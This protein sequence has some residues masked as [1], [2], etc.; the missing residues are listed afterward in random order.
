MP[1]LQPTTRPVQPK[2]QSGAI[3]KGDHFAK[4]YTQDIMLPR[5]G[6]S[7]QCATISCSR[8][9]KACSTP[10]CLHF[11]FLLLNMPPVSEEGCWILPRQQR[12]CGCPG[13]FADKD[14]DAKAR[15]EDKKKKSKEEEFSD[16]MSAIAVDV[17]EV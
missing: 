3:P 14:A 11:L 17:Q 1:L 9:K 6:I 5:T 10:Q 7:P 8:H 15:G 16:F 13:F 4:L 12:M 2:E